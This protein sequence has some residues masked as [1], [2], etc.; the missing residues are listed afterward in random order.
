MHIELSSIPTWKDESSTSSYPEVYG[1]FP[2]DDLINSKISLWK[3]DS[4]KLKVDAIV[5]A[6]NTT[7]LGGGGID[8]AIHRAAG[9]ELVRECRTLNGCPTGQTKVTK[10]YRLPSRFILHTVGPI[11]ENQELLQSC[12]QTC[13]DKIDGVDIRSLAFCGIS[14]GIYGYPVR[15]ACNVALS[16][17]RRWLS[18]PHNQEK[19]D[20]IIFVIFDS[21][22]VSAYKKFFPMY[23]P[24]CKPVVPSE[25][26]KPSEQSS[27]PVVNSHHGFSDTSDSD[28]SASD[29]DSC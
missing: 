8:G 21:E 18:N 27:E 5:N 9:P 29:S 7:L 14:T 4:T 28:S 22:S 1:D 11:G 24:N 20:R 15:K 6:A 16:T 13:L 2:C 12:Y 17:I 3:G 26:E 10:A 19:V 25:E 23:F